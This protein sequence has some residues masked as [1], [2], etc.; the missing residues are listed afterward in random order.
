MPPTPP[1][2]Y[3]GRNSAKDVAGRMWDV[4]SE[5]LPALQSEVHAVEARVEDELDAPD[6]AAI[7]L[8]GLE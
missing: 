7:F 5:A 3:S 2:E 6:F 8:S 1:P 4:E